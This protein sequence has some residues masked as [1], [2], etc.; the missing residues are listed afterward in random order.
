M[1]VDIIFTGEERRN[2]FLTRRQGDSSLTHPVKFT[3]NK[4]HKNYKLVLTLNP[5]PHDKLNSFQLYEQQ[6]VN[7]LFFLSKTQKVKI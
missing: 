5:L 3:I 2:I 7:I 1:V 6:K 4:S